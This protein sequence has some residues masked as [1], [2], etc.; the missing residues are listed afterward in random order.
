MISFSC[1]NCDDQLVFFENTECLRCGTLLGFDAGALT[2]VA[3]E[4]L[5]AEAR[6]CANRTVAA[7]NWLV[8]AP[9]SL[10]RSC[11]LTRT[12][13]SDAD[14]SA[15]AAFAETEAAKRRLVFQALD[16]GL[17]LDSWQD[18]PGGLGYDMLSSRDADVVIGH[19]DGIITI[20][21]AETDDPTREQVRQDMGEAYRTMLGHLRHETGHW[22]WYELVSTP[23]LSEPF[24]ELF[25]DERASYSDALDRHYA[26][27]APSNWSESYVSAYATMHPWEDFAETFA[28]YLHIRDTLQTAASYDMRI[29]VQG[30]SAD[31]EVEVDDEP[32]RDILA[33][34]LPLTYALNAVNRSMGSGDLYPFVL[35]P[36]VVRKLTW[37]HHRVTPVENQ[38]LAL[39]ASEADLPATDPSPDSPTAE[40]SETEPAGEAAEA[41]PPGEA[42]AQQRSR[43]ARLF[44]GRR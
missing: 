38:E 13:P 15:L 39:E 4:P 40:G 10:C 33:D 17:P 2:L 30:L 6:Y 26:A 24:R 16:L 23:G 1:P 37:V 29:D 35:S 27:G 43:F 42:Q 7:C 25:G 19:V 36:E 41:E 11:R 18:R 8:D 20:D 28:H 9:G 22:Y 44:P 31:P 14:T 12:R 5:D 32:F 21:L 34:W 3:V